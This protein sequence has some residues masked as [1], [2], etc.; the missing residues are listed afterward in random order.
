M[1]KISNFIKKDMK[2]SCAE[3]I[4]V[5]N[6]HN[7][8]LLPWAQYRLK[9][10]TPPPAVLV[11]DHHTDVMPSFR[12]ENIVIEKDC[13]KDL[14]ELTRTIEKLK[15]D[16]HFHFAVASHLVKECLISA[17]VN[18]TKPA[19]PALKVLWDERW[20]DE[21]KVFA[22]PEKY[23]TLADSVLESD[24]LEA[25]F[26]KEL[27]EHFILDIDCDYFATLK[28]LFPEDPRYFEKMV[29]SADLITISLEKEWVRL[30]RFPGE[31]ILTAEK[32]VQTLFE[33]E[34]E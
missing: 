15:H 32:I 26:G 30:L 12:D 7:E 31:N 28:S 3:K 8:V 4:F 34:K 11:L 29:K 13:W 25:R 6:S 19:H 27:P 24:Y 23:R 1:W 18:G 5:V 16:E 20:E 9:C 22:A 14:T 33:K 10:N 21:N 17:C 2:F